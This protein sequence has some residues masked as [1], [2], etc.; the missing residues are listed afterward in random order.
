MDAQV[1]SELTQVM[2]KQNEK[3]PSNQPALSMQDILLQGWTGKRLFRIRLEEEHSPNFE[4]SSLLGGGQDDK[5]KMPTII[6]EIE[7]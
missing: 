5:S 7:I 6:V 2:E 4:E 1:F 3:Y